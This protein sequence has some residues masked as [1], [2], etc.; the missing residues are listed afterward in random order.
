MKSGY[1][2]VSS[3]A[4]KPE[5]TAETLLYTQPH[6]KKY[7]PLF[8]SNAHTHQKVGK[9]G[10]HSKVVKFDYLEIGPSRLN[11][12]L[13]ILTVNAIHVTVTDNNFS[14]HKK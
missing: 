7:L 13:Y 11:D 10:Q 5:C 14:C 12:L 4:L 6:F 9:T 2:G 8:P 3:S 1:L